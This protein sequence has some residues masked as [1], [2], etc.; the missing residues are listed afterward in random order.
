MDKQTDQTTTYQL[1][2]K[3]REPETFT[4]AKQAGA[5]WFK[6]ELSDKSVMTVQQGGQAARVFAQVGKEGTQ[7][8]KDLPFDNMPGAADF[9]ASFK[10]ALELRKA[11]QSG[12]ASGKPAEAL[13][14]AKPMDMPGLKNAERGQTYEGKIVAM[15][16]NLVIQAVIDGQKTLHVAHER[17]ALSSAKAGLL[18]QGKDLSIR[19]PFAGVGI[20]QERQL[21]HERKTPS[22]QPK[23]FGG[24]GF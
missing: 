20:V 1:F 14:V 4:D 13:A 17:S 12:V 18:H 5:A 22:H 15:R 24:K 23:G 6:A 19:Y 10:E 21:Q 7:Y 3:G 2:Q 9:K 11:E 8:Y 16:D